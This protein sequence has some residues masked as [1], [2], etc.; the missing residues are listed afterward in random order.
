MIINFKDGLTD[1]QKKGIED[2][3]TNRKVSDWNDQD[4]A[5]WF[6][7][8]N[9]QAL[10]EDKPLRTLFIDL[11]HSSKFPGASGYKTE[12]LLSR[13]IYRHLDGII[14]GWKIVLVP[15]TYKWDWSSNINL[16][17]RIRFI[18]RNCK[19]GDWV[20]SIHGNAGPSHVRGVTTCYMGGSRY[21]L[22]HAYM[23]S[24]S[25]ANASDLPIWGGGAFDDRT[26][27]FGRLGMVRD[28]KPP[29]VL[30]EAG[31]V[32]NHKDMATDPRLIAKGIANFFN[33][34]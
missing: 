25:V 19:D 27:R 12:V 11:G 10:P 5:N 3:A 30:L 23:L 34:L 16:I 32:T 7:A 2:L 6:Y 29:A 28:T 1:H 8:T 26:A 21:M 15:E 33:N 14:K 18:N 20:L 4:R 22:N 9:G 17:H 24:H 31:F 13:A